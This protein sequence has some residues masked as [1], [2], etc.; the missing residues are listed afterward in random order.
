M[1]LGLCEVLVEFSE[2]PRVVW[3]FELNLDNE[4]WMSCPEPTP[5][6]VLALEDHC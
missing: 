5:W 4:G 3:Y 6:A 2:V 1:I